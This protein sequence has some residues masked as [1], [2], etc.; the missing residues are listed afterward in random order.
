MSF[1]LSQEEY[2]ELKSV[3]AKTGQMVKE[4][5]L[6]SLHRILSGSPITSLKAAKGEL[7]LVAQKS[8]LSSRRE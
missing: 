4:I 2:E 1:T 5:I 8:T 7:G 3:Q 6:S